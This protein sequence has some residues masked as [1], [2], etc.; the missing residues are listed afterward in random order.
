MRSRVR[1]R[2][3]AWTALVIG[4]GVLLVA[5]MAVGAVLPRL[6]SGVIASRLA[7]QTAARGVEVK[8]GARPSWRLLR[9]EI[10]TL[11]VDLREA[12]F[13]RLPV[14][15]FLLDAY[16]LRLDAPR[17]WR[18]GVLRVLRHGRLTA[19][20]RLTEADLNQYLWATA[21]RERAF[22]LTLGRG[23][24][25]ADGTLKVLGQPVPLRLK[26]RFVIDEPATL[27][28]VPDEF[29]L[30]KMSVPR[31]ILENVVAKVFYVRIQVEE[32]PVKVRLTEVRVE[33][34]RLFLFAAN[35]AQ[36]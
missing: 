34:G 24:A 15:S 7:G 17:L 18:T 12:R 9:G 4:A 22:R 8:A 2:R 28:F 32:L 20:L 30:A 5:M 10:D 29:F 1:G 3:L 26:G 36:V 16:D 27:R 25:Q 13:G 6:L 11:H 33:P 31:A 14:N 35:P 21:D 19:T 23:F